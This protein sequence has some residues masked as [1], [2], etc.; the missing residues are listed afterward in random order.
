MAVTERHLLGSHDYP[1][2]AITR[3]IHGTWVMEPHS[4]VPVELLNEALEELCPV[5]LAEGG[6]ARN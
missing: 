5:L 4:A 3:V 1:K 2:C 6:A